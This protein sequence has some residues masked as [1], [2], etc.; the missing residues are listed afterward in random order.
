MY[1]CMCVYTYYIINVTHICV[2]DERENLEDTNYKH[3]FIILA[4]KLPN[5]K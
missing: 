5:H 1:L 2:Y 4:E 3:K